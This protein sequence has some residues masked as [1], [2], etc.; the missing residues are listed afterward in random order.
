MRFLLRLRDFVV[1]E[2]FLYVM[3]PLIWQ[4]FCSRLAFKVLDAFIK[5]IN[6]LCPRVLG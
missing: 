5:I 2:N 6:L 1:V 3:M 4:P